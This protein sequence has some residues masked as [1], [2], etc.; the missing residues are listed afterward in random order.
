M[1]ARDFNLYYLMQS[2]TTLNLGININ[3]FYKMLKSIKKKDSLVLF[4]TDD[5]PTELGI[6][7][8]PKDHSRLTIS[9]IR[10]Q[11]IQNLEIALPEPYPQSILVSA[12]EFSKMCK[13]M[14]NISNTISVQATEWN[15]KFVCNLGSVYSREVILGE[16]EHERQNNS[17]TTFTTFHQVCFEDDFDAEQLSRIMKI[18]GLSSNLNIHCTPDMPI[19]IRTKIGTLGTISI[20]IKSKRQIEEEEITSSELN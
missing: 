16:T 20:Y 8:I 10:I 3:H 7:I 5:R 11:N 2:T 13:D 1:N 9:Y 6:Q 19:L 12:A 4:I 15:V 17:T 18:S 14:F